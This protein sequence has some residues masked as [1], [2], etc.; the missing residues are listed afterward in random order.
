M[1]CDSTPDF[2]AEKSRPLPVIGVRR[3]AMQSRAH[4]DDRV[5]PAVALAPELPLASAF[6]PSRLPEK[7]FF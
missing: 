2:I 6:Q 4:D 7:V 5:A 1:A 3:A